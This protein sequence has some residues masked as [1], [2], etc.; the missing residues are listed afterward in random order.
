[1]SS[2]TPSFHPRRHTEPSLQHSC[3]SGKSGATSTP[4]APGRASRV[5]F[6]TQQL[7]S[8]L[9]FK[10]NVS[11]GTNFHPHTRANTPAYYLWTQKYVICDKHMSANATRCMTETGPGA[12]RENG[13]EEGMNDPPGIASSMP[14]SSKKGSMK[15]IR[16][17]VT[18]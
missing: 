1:M 7:G 5:V 13:T 2:E 17:D 10:V 14:M 3:D 6:N 4:P 9:T 12:G 16:H 18:I 15:P 11:T 8:S